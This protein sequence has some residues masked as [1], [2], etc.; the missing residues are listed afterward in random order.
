MLVFDLCPNDRLL[1]RTG[2]EIRGDLRVAIPDY[3]TLMLPL[4]KR[5][6]KK[7]VRV[8]EI[9]DDIA[10]EFHLSEA[11][12]EQLLQSG[13]QRVLENRLHWAKIYLSRAGLLETPTRGLFVATN[14]GRELLATKPEKID[15][16]LLKQY[17]SFLEFYKASSR[18][19][20]TTDTSSEEAPQLKA[21]TPEE[22]IESAYQTV[23]S[24]LRADLLNRIL[25]NSPAF[26][27]QLIVDLMVRMGY[28]GSHESAA[29][30]LGR[31]GDG[32]IDGILNEDRLGLDR[33]YLQA[34]RY[35]QDNPVG[36]PDVQAFV[37]SLVGRGATK[38]VFVTTSKFS[39]Q[40]DEFVR[41]LT[42]RIVLIDGAQLA[43]LMIEHNVGTR[44]SRTVEFKR[45]DEDFF[46]EES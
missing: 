24:A 10:D 37:G 30:R 41:H 2:G 8:P 1:G 39:A 9:R 26:F 20:R 46:S 25:Q 16:S 38:G 3:Q 31:A 13:T 43:D 35:A 18:P 23:H 36:R 5:A 44:V 32:G 29:A 12:R 22:Q 17:P 7:A 45:L 42:Q 40:A 6:E 14:L 34:K 21:A 28:G 27:E 33:I 15:N 19:G 4:L 11:E